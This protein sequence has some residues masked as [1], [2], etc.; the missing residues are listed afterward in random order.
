MNVHNWGEPERA[1]HLSNGVPAIYLSMIYRTSF[2]KCPHVLIHW[3]ASILQC[4]IQF[5][6]CH[7]VQIIQTASILHVQ[8]AYSTTNKCTFDSRL[9]TVTAW[10]KGG[11]HNIFACVALRPEVNV[12]AC[13]NAGIEKFSIPALRCIATRV[14]INLY[15][16]LVQRDASKIL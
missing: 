15:A 6:K 13:C 1:P 12:N 5:R 16:L 7:H 2:R 4:V 3:T 14:Q 10:T 8:W 11:V 9:D